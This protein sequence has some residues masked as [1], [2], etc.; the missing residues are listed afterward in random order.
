MK[1]LLYLTVVLFFLWNNVFAQTLPNSGFE[2]LDVNG[3][4]DEW[5]GDGFGSGASS[6]SH[7]GNNSLSV[8]NW[9][10]YAKGFTVNGSAVSVF[11]LN[12]AGTPYTQKATS[13]N[14][15]YRY[16]TVD[17]YS[18][19]DSAQITVLLKK[20]NTITQQV[21]TIG[22]GV[23]HLP[24][25]APGD[26]TFAPFSLQIDDWDAGQQP[27]SIVVLFQ[28][29]LNGFCENADDGNCLYFN[30][31][32]L[33]LVTPLGL[34]DLN[35]SKIELKAFPNPFQDEITLS[36][37]SMENTN[38]NVFIKDITGKII[39]SVQTTLVEGINTVRIDFSELIA[40]IYF[41]EVQMQ[42]ESGMIKLVKN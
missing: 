24:A 40:G 28:S 20:R 41:A 27:D 17:T 22:F 7:S 10:Y 29:S 14:G 38:G 26:G 42:N 13:L 4:P 3:F 21:D 33:S 30:V 35:Q 6:S 32:D 11:Q 8:W 18:N 23:L 12:G 36:V 25:H 16:D 2:N 37:P 31:D 34:T 1:K 39:R 15:F 9:Y 19:F 5:T